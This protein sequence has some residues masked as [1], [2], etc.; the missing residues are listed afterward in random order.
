MKTAFWISFAAATVV[1]LIMVLWS[2]PA[3]SQAAGGLVPFD[4]RPGGYSHAEARAFLAQL[5]D[6]GRLLYQ[7][8]Q[9]WLD[10]AYP[11]LLGLTL[12]LGMMVIYGGIFGKIGAALAVLVAV[13]D[14]LEN[15]AVAVLLKADL[16]DVSEAMVAAA[17]RW[18][19][20]K[21]GLSTVVFVALMVGALRVAW[22]RWKA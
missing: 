1:Y 21:S 3:I 18:T 4:M 20:A 12:A 22:R 15:A 8:T 13:T 19:V 6:E 17:S 5:S 7:G 10:S 11:A 16:G 9:H 2:L 14:Y